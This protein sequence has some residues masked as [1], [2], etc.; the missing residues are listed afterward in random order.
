MDTKKT[1]KKKEHEEK[2]EEFVR[3]EEAMKAILSVPADEVK[4]LKEEDKEK[5]RKKKPEE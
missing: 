4:R 1:D 5:Q 2:S 3:F